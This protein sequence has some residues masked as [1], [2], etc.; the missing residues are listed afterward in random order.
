MQEISVVCRAVPTVSSPPGAQTV[1]LT[2]QGLREP[3][4]ITDKLTR[5]QIT[6][7]AA[8]SRQLWEQLAAVLPSDSQPDR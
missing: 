1:C 3:R 4:T 6:L 8:Q 5:V 2:F 7:P